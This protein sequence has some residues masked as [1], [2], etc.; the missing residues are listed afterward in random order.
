MELPDDVLQII[1]E[2]SQPVTRP[3]WRSLHR[4][5]TVSFHMLAAQAIN[6]TLP[7]SVF[8]MV[9][10]NDTGFTYNLEYYYNGLP[11]IDYIYTPNGTPV[12]VPF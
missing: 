6:R 11:C 9:N 2:F 7:Q 4:M 5:P 8:E 1:K 12:E 3:D 10:E